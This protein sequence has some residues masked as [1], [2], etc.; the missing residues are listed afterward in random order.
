MFGL[1][2][3]NFFED[4]QQH[5]LLHHELSSENSVASEEPCSSL[6][7]TAPSVPNLLL[8]VMAFLQPELGIRFFYLKKIDF[9]MVNLTHVGK[10]GLF[11]PMF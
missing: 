9:L 11:F 8:T 1:S 2:Y 3:G 5:V 6:T 4:K 10:E 7:G